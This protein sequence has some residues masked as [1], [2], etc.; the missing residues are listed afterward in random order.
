MGATFRKKGIDQPGQAGQPGQY[1]DKAVP[2][3]LL[4]VQAAKELCEA[5]ASM[6]ENPVISAFIGSTY[7]SLKDMALQAYPEAAAQIQW[8]DGVGTVADGAEGELVDDQKNNPVAADPAA[9]AADPAAEDGADDF[10]LSSMNDDEDSD[11][12]A[13]E[14]E[15]EDEDEGMMEDGDEDEET[16]EDE[17][18]MMEDGD[19]DEETMEDE[20]EGMMEDGDEDEDEMM[21]DEDE[22]MMEDG[23]EDEDEMMEDE[24]EGALEDSD[25]DEDIMEDEDE[26]EEEDE[27][28]APPKAKGKG[29]SPF[30]DFGSIGAK[31][32]KALG[33]LDKILEDTTSSVSSLSDSVGDLVDRIKKMTGRID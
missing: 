32:K 27:E 10:D 23:D 13:M 2:P 14:S 4:F 12:F 18:E 3:G 15:D 22:G 28:D 17:D 21:E 11:P 26:D 20:D 8:Q 1:S 7:A 9:A 19:E 29:K 24:D 30:P 33:N 6:Q 31:K 25:E 5:A 16:M